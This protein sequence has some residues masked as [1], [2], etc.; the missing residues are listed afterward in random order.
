MRIHALDSSIPATVKFIALPVLQN[1]TLR[2]EYS[3]SGDGLSRKAGQWV[4]L[5]FYCIAY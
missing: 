1:T 5:I 2:L 4:T 3:D